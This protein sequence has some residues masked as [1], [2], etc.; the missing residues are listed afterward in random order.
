M[1]HFSRCILLDFTYPF[2][3][4]Q[5]Y[6]HFNSTLMLLKVNDCIQ[7]LGSVFT[8]HVLHHIIQQFDLKN[9]INSNIKVFPGKKCW[10]LYVRFWIVNWGTLLIVTGKSLSGIWIRIVKMTLY[11]S[12]CVYFYSNMHIMS[13]PHIKKLIFILHNHFV[14]IFYALKWN[15]DVKGCAWSYYQCC[16]LNK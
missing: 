16:I 7:Q 2:R 13:C 8:F 6:S 10:W 3:K 9:P 4:R 12:T 14:K 1:K 5:P 15:L 11:H